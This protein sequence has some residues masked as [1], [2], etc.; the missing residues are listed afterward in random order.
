MDVLVA[1]ISPIRRYR[2]FHPSQATLSALISAPVA[3][4]RP[5]Q[6][7]T[8]SIMTL[9][10]FSLA[11]LVGIGLLLPAARSQAQLF[12]ISIGDRPYYSHGASYWDGDTHYVW[13]PGRANS[14]GRWIHGRYIVRERREAVR[15]YKHKHDKHKHWKHHDH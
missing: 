13:A 9:R 14:G 10:K 3:V 5:H 8:V 11:G 2:R 4:R 7:R 6:P 15:P 1:G 12:N